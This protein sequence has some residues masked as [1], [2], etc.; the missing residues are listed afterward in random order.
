MQPGPFGRGQLVVGVLAEQV[1]REAV[2]AGLVPAHYPGPGGRGEGL[3]RGAGR[4][5]GHQGDQVRGE[6]LADH[7]G[8]PQRGGRGAGQAR[9]PQFHGLVRAGRDTLLTAAQQPRDLLHEERV[10]AGPPVH[11]GRDLRR[12][13][14]PHGVRD[15]VADRGRAE[16]GQRQHG[17][18]RRQRGQRRAG[19]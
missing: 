3:G 6:P 2:G 8:R 7:G 9:E 17:G 16:P 18:P 1:V 4:L 12:A 14:L 13:L 10:A 5:A 19:S 11:A 15:Q